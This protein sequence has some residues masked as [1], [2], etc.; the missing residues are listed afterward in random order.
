M[1]T[2]TLAALGD[3]VLSRSDIVIAVVAGGILAKAHTH[4]AEIHFGSPRRPWRIWP[5]VSSPSAIPLLPSRTS[6]SCSAFHLLILPAQK[7]CLLMLPRQK[8]III[9]ETLKE[10]KP[11]R[12]IA[13]NS[14]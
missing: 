12:I 5:P 3:T 11:P 7:E 13:H 4:H 2:V 10:G 9:A 1:A 8:Q 6:L 14:L